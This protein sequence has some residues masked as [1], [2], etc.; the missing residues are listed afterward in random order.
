MGC[1]IYQAGAEL[2]VDQSSPL[3]G[4]ETGGG[5]I[6]YC[7][8]PRSGAPPLR[9]RG[10]CGAKG[11]AMKGVIFVGDRQ[12]DMREV[13]KPTSGPGEVVLAMEASGLCGSD[14]RTYRMPKTQRD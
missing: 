4:E 7:L 13:P 5:G 2:A 9:E 14:L 11:V 10:I 12:I 1:A 8:A 6:L 3:A